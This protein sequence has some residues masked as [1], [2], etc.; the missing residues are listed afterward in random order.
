MTLLRG[1]VVERDD[2]FLLLLAVVGC[3][4]M[5]WAVPV[6]FWEWYVPPPNVPFEHVLI[7]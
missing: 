5:V 4:G 7:T 3:V 2:F 6:F 1:N